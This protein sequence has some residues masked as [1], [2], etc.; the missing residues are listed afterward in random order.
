MG[1]HII[2]N[3]INSINNDWSLN[4]DAGVNSRED[5]YEQSGVNST[6]QL[7]FGLLDHSNF[8]SK[9]TIGD[10]FGA[11]YMILILRGYKT[12]ACSRKHRSI[13]KNGSL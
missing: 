12:S 10:D 13:S 1:S 6:Q 8:I 9:S 2:A 7:V 3:Y 5:Y 11:S 4:I